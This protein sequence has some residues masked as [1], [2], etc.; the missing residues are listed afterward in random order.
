MMDLLPFSLVIASAVSHASWNLLAKQCSDKEVFL[1]W[2]TFT[3]LFTLLPLFY[4]ILPDWCLPPA[5]VPYLL[6]SG[7]AETLYFLS[8][9]RAYELGD[10]SVVYP[11]ARS[12]PLFL[13]I[14]AVV[15]LGEEVSK[16][17]ALGIL[18]VVLGVYTLH[19]RG[20]SSTEFLTPLTSLRGR[21]S[22]LA[23]L[24]AFWT[25]LYSLIDKMGVMAVD[26][27][28]Y[29]FWLD[30]FIAAFLTPVVLLR[31]G[32]SATV[33]EWRRSSLRV[34]V[35][36]FLMRFGYVLV[37]LAMSLTQVSYILAVRQLSVV[38]GAALGVGLLGEKYGGVRLLGSLIIFMGVLILGT[39][40]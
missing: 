26:P 10:L 18:L 8:L 22:Q 11:L 3:S 40:T 29:A 9:G 28:Q 1:W 38:I 25:S 30:F 5:A 13:F 2:T 7:V 24:T 37:L 23:L 12:S 27:L 17:G 36:G 19:L 16:W 21:A 6:A 14:L 32:W 20:L 15:F 33:S 31:R 4:L 39:M 34:L 35:S